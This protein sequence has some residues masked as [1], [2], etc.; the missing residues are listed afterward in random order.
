MRYLILVSVLWSFSFGIIKYGLP[1]LDSFFISYTRNLIALA[2]FASVSI[3]QIKQFKWDI[4]LAVIGAIQFGRKTPGECMLPKPVP[5]V[6]Y[7]SQFSILSLTF[8]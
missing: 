6:N 1:N 7:L 4:Q 3:Y 5:G 8:V 2:F